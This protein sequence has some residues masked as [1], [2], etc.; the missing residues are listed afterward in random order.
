[1]SD[2]LLADRPA[3]G[4]DRTQSAVLSLWGLVRRYPALGIG[5][6][7]ILAMVVIG[8]AAPLFTSRHPNDLN[9]YIRLSAPSSDYW[10]GTDGFGRDVYARTMFGA[11]VSLIVGFAVAIVSTLTGAILGAITGYF[12]RVD[13][14]I[15]RVMDGLMAIP[16]ILL[17]IALMALLGPSVQNVIV[18]LAV[19]NSPRT[20]RVV[21]SSVLSLKTQPF[22]DA[23]RSIGVRPPRILARH[24]VPNTIAPL[25]V[26]GTYVGAVAILL[27]ASLSFL[28]AGIPPDLPSWG[29]I[30]AEGRGFTRRA[31][32][33]IF[34]PGLFLTATVL[35]VNLVG[36]GLRDMLDPR[37]SRRG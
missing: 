21:R 5:L 27:E 17:A 34:F 25:I 13:G 7:V 35:G 22:V 32:W 29:N 26:M 3:T 28:G 8:A 31:M 4:W 1:M 30:M 19:A 37:V 12:T 2:S 10:F 20:V 9:T 36:D 23:A 6:I 15:M 24:I 18:S 33:I 11:R 16:E 14:V